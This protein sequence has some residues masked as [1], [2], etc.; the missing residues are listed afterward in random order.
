MRQ[1]HQF[2][3]FLFLTLTYE[4]AANGL[5]KKHPG[6]S[7]DEKSGMISGYTNR[8]GDQISWQ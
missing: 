5:Q 3:S 2:F 8:Y 6:F 4:S 7:I 1:F